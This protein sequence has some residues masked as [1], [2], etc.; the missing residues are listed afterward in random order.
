[1]T[2]I[3]A[4]ETALLRGELIVMPT[5]T[6]YGVAASPTVEGAIRSGERSAIQLMDQLRAG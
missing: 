3:A 4:A 5:D 1:M 6:V 2:Q